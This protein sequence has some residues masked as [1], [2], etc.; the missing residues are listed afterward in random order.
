[1]SHVFSVRADALRRDA[2]RKILLDPAAPQRAARRMPARGCHIVLEPK[3]LV[4]K[5]AAIE[6]AAAEA[7][8]NPGMILCSRVPLNEY[9]TGR[10]SCSPRQRARK[11]AAVLARNV[12]LDAACRRR[13]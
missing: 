11:F 12:G 1:M 8:M 9:S 5:G 6:G 2:T 4:L 13:L 3:A 10:P 7:A